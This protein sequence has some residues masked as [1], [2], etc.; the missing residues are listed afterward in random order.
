MP[1][2]L[3]DPL[4]MSPNRAFCVTDTVTFYFPP[5]I[6]RQTKGLF[7]NATGSVSLLWKFHSKRA[8]PMYKALIQKSSDVKKTLAP[9]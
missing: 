7:Q 5:A 3:K 1:K 8:A 4:S 2:A 6:I 9:V